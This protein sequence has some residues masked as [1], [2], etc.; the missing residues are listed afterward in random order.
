MGISERK[1]R[2]LEEMKPR[3]IDAAIQTFLEEV[4]YSPS[5]SYL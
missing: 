4:T 5:V 3:I 2:D 1:E